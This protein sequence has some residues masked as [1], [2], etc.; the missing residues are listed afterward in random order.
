VSDAEAQTIASSIQAAAATGDTG[1]FASH[2]DFEALGKLV[3]AGMDGTNREA[4]NLRTAI[5]K[6]MHLIGPKLTD[7]IFRHMQAG[8]SYV[9]LRA[10]DRQ[11][12][13]RLLFRLRTADNTLNYHELYLVRQPQGLRIVDLF[14]YISGERLSVTMQRILLAALPPEKQTLWA[15]LSGSAR[16]SLRR[17]APLQEMTAAFKRGESQRAVEIYRSLPSDLQK[18]KSIQLIHVMA[19][20]KLDEQ[21]YAA[22][23]DEFRTSF[24][25]DPSIH[26]VSIDAHLLAGRFDDAHQALDRLDQQL[27]GDRYLQIMHGQ[28]LAQE[29]KFDLAE[30]AAEA[31]LRDDARDLDAHWLLVHVSMA[32]RAFPTTAKLLMKIRDELAVELHDLTQIPEYAEFVASPAFAELQKPS[33]T[34]NPPPASASSPVPPSQ[35]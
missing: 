3:I 33:P 4:N 22:A 30:K 26:L 10:L 28:I 8:G 2:F 31:C 18:V 6:Q 19:S 27:G 12:G 11:D 20:Q 35:P 29:G 15:S 1:G 9:F 25:T 21:A 5:I 34:P 24:P 13:R 7:E 17:T 14:V 23:I 32:R 16:E